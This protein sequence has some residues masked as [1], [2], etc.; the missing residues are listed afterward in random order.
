[1]ADRRGA[2]GVI[3]A[4]ILGQGWLGAGALPADGS[5]PAAFATVSPSEVGAVARS[6]RAVMSCDRNG[7]DTG[8]TH[9][10]GESDQRRDGRENDN[11]CDDD[12]A[13]L[14]PVVVP[15]VVV[16]PVVVPPVVVPPAV[17]PPATTYPGPVAIAPGLSPTVPPGTPPVTFTPLPG[18]II[19]TRPGVPGTG[20]VA[21]TNVFVGYVPG[22]SIPLFR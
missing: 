3:A 6:S 13:A 15:P 18:A 14:P 4:L 5:T 8:S 12:V 22:T 9:V 10:I 21:P 7:E 19:V 2:V 20:S 11:E 16:P 17:V 1:M